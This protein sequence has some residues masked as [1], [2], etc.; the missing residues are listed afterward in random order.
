MSRSTGIADE[1]LLA[2]DPI[3]IR[4]S[5]QRQLRVRATEVALAVSATP[6]RPRGIANA[7][8]RRA[9]RIF[10]KRLKSPAVGKHWYAATVQQPSPTRIVWM[11][12]ARSME[13]LLRNQWPAFLVAL[14]GE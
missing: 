14:H 13:F 7:G 11:L 2:P 8:A 3:V 1:K 10:C 4:N 5:I 9:I 12:N 6:D